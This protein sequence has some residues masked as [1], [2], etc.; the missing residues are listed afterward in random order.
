[1]IN[2]QLVKI[3]T[4]IDN[5]QTMR[6]F[7]KEIFTS[8]ELDDLSLRWRLLTELHKNKTQRSIAKKHHISLCKITRGSKIL[9]KKNSVTKQLLENIYN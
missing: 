2:K 6:K 8:K 1:M 7:F 5:E 4:E 3:F 9:Q